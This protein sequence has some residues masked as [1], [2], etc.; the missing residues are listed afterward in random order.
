MRY[1]FHA[2]LW[3]RL[4]LDYEDTGGSTILLFGFVPLGAGR[5]RMDVDILFFDP[6]GF[7][8]EQLDERLAFEERVVGE[9]L[10]LQ[11]QFDDLRLPL[12]PSAELHTKADRYSVVCRNVIRTLLDEVDANSVRTTYCVR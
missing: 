5:A 3:L 12:D 4:Q 6:A 10:A 8:E 9:D 2:P 11:Q 7:T 1:A